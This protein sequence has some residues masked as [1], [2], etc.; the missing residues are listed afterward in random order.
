MALQLGATLHGKVDATVS[1]LAVLGIGFLVFAVVL[2]IFTIIDTRE[3][4]QAQRLAF[5]TGLILLFASLVSAVVMP[6][7]QPPPGLGDLPMKAPR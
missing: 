2:S 7:P 3:V 6:A 1:I 5:L 4:K